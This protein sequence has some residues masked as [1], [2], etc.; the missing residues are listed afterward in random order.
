MTGRLTVECVT[1]RVAADAYGLN[2]D[3][4]FCYVVISEGFH[5]GG[6]PQDD[7]LPPRTAVVAQEFVY[8]RPDEGPVWTGKWAVE[9]I[10]DG[11]PQCNFPVLT[12][13]DALRIA[14]DWCRTDRG[15]GVLL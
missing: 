14:K 6:D 9:F 11:E 7:E 10:E 5:L 1:A 12:L 8:R 15:Q 3:A 13:D 2:V 4:E